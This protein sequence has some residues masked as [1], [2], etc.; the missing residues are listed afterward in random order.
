MLVLN[1][2]EESSSGDAHQTRAPYTAVPAV[3][4]KL[5]QLRSSGNLVH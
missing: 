5:L 2:L 3:P 1:L 4:N